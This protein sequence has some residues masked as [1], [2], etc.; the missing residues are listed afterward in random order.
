ML[1]LLKTE[2]VPVRYG[3]K[4]V[5]NVTPASPSLHLSLR[6][7]FLCS[8]HLFVAVRG[9]ALDRA[10]VEAIPVMSRAVAIDLYRDKYMSFGTC[11]LYHSV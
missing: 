9:G 8:L 1:M 6:P 3:M 4:E 10:A 7:V 5:S 11:E 2:E